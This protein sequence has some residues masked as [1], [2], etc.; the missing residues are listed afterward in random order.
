MI[1]M[2]AFRRMSHDFACLAVTH[3]GGGATTALRQDKSRS[4]WPGWPAADGRKIS[5]LPRCAL[6]SDSLHFGKFRAAST[7]V[8]PRAPRTS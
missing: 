3:G 1:A 7:I 6:S 8:A 4:L 2:T 5:D